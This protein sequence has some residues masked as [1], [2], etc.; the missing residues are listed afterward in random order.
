MASEA[1]FAALRGAGPVE[2]SSGKTNADASTAG[3]DQQANAVHYHIVLT[4]LRWRPH[5]RAYLNRRTSDG[6]SRARPND[7]PKLLSGPNRRLG[8]RKP[9]QLLHPNQ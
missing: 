4:C 5:T 3:G 2:A 6:K 1:S 9:R 8:P 7:N